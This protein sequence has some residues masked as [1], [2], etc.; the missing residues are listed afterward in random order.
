[1]YVIPTKGFTVRD[2][3]TKRALP[4][5][6]ADVPDNIF[7]QRRLRDGDVTIGTPPATS[8]V[9]AVKSATSAMFTGAQPTATA[10][11]EPVKS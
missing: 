5:E 10:A 3:V 6:G 9:A 7:W 2:P 8:T 1:M 11:A 4:P